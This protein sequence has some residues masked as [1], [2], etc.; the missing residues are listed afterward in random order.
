MARI[1]IN[2][3]GI[4]YELLGKEGN[5]AVALTP[6]GRFTKET[7]GLREMAEVFVAAGKRVLIWDR[8]NCGA[9]D[10]TLEG[11]SESGIN[12]RTLAAMIRELKLGP[13]ALAAGSAGARVSM[14]AAAAA[15]DLISHL[16]IWWISGGPIG[17]MGLAVYYYG[18]AAN[19][20]GQGGMAA[21]AKT[22]G[23]TEYMQQN[24]KAREQILAYDP[25]K[26]IE[27][28]QAWAKGFRPP[29][30]SPVPGMTPASFADLKMP[31]LIFR[32]GK[33]DVPHTR[34]TSEWVHKLI[35]QSKLVEP[36]WGDTEWNDRTR[37][38]ATGKEKGLFIN[39][40]KL[41][42]IILDFIKN[43]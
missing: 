33:S 10:F 17:L 27:K 5:P 40:P 1:T 7:P 37:D 42:P 8:P 2:G 30:D 13:T 36:P 39:W 28:M 9:S 20:I 34:A 41:A 21:V 38:V 11:D 22:R 24:A 6:G 14:I 4:E 3:V 32:S 29:D 15:P 18:D 43:N 16:C 23:W 25:E 35:P 12:G 26:F 31:V 19:A